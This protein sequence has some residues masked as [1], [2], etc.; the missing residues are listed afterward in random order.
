MGLPADETFYI[1]DDVL[2]LYREA[3]VRGRAE[4][5][6]WQARFDAWDGDKAAWA[7]GGPAP[8]CPGWA[9]ALPTLR[10]GREGRPPAWRAVRCFQALM[11]TVPGLHGR[12]RRPVGQHGHRAQGRGRPVAGRAHRPP[13]LL[14]HPRAR[15]GRGD[16]RHG[17]PRRH[18]AGRRHLP[19]SSATT[20]ARRCAWPPSAGAKVIFSFTHDSVGLGED[21]PTHQPIEHLMALRAIPGLRVIRPADANETVGRLAGRHRAARAPRRWPCP[22]RTSRSSPAPATRASPAAPTWWPARDGGEP[23]A[24]ALGTGA[25]SRVCVEAAEILRAEGRTV[26]VVSMPWWDLFAAEDFDY[27]DEVLPAG[28]PTLAVEAGVVAR[29]GPLGRRQRRHRPLRRVGPRHRGAAPPGLHARQRGRARPRADRRPGRGHLRRSGDDPHPPIPRRVAEMTKLHEL[30]DEQGQSPWLDNLRRSWLQGGEL[31]DWVAKG[32]RGVT[33]NPSI[34]Q[35]AIA[36]LGRLRRPVRRGPRQAGCRSRTSTGSWSCSDIEGALAVLRPTYDES[37]G[38][39][40]YVSV[41]VAP[42]LARDTEG[43]TAAARDLHER[44]DE[45]NLYVKIPGTAEGLPAIRHDDRRGP[46]RQR[47]PPVQPQPL[48][49]GH[50]GPPGRARGAG[51]VGGVTRG[52]RTGL[53]GGVVLRQPGRRRGRPAPRRHRHRRGPALQGQGR[54]RQRP[55]GLRPVPGALLRAPLGGAGR[56]RGPGPAP[57][58]GLDLDQGPELPRHPLRRHADRPGHGQHAA[59]RHPR[60]LPR[61]RH[62]GPHGRHRARRRPRRARPPGPRRHRPRRRHRAAGEGGR[63]RLR[64]LVR[65]PHRPPSAEKADQLKAGGAG[66]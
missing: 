41:E 31:A 25:R 22:A 13:D 58:V 28:V 17:P 32:V 54:R 6:A 44:I 65:R 56:R 10:A 45:P 37:D 61:P 4:H 38:L 34:F 12:R 3:G 11:G 1:P 16:E 36:G 43:T 29:L 8:A 63:R 52:R 2:E 48:R 55:P 30:Y 66:T 50:R 26:R 53:V 49:R 7:A 18:A 15:H 23:D 27:Q 47:H 42:S 62:R 9:D 19:R 21:G 33:S 40:G 46:Q 57:A 51:R 20:A 59:R 24:R 35:K 5:E 60:G 64:G 14:R 39:D